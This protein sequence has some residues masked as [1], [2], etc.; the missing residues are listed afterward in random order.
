MRNI[1]YILD[2]QGCAG[3]A[4]CGVRQQERISP[5]RAKLPKVRVRQCPTVMKDMAESLGFFLNPETSR[6]PNFESAFLLRSIRA[7]IQL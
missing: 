5:P 7:I 6:E 3:D 2:E 4:S 1:L